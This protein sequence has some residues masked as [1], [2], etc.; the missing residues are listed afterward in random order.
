MNTSE[1][2]K[3]MIEHEASDL[4]LRTNSV[5]RARIFGVVQELN[6]PVL[7]EKQM[8]EVTDRLLATDQRRRRFEQNLDIDFAYFE[9][10]SQ[11]SHFLID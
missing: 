10:F 4:F 2:L 1:L 11:N 8:R 5:P 9:P 6:A 3:L 7:N